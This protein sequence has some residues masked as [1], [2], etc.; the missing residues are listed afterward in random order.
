MS[1]TKTNL[2]NRHHSGKKRSLR[3]QAPKNVNYFEL[4]EDS[5]NEEDLEDEDLY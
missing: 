3:E 5:Y 2:K 4:I 1:K